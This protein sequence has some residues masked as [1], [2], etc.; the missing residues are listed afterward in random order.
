MHDSQVSLSPCV[1][2]LAPDILVQPSLHTTNSTHKKVKTSK[3][4]NHAHSSQEMVEQEVQD[5]ARRWTRHT[6]VN[7]RDSCV[8]IRIRSSAFGAHLFTHCGK[9][10]AVS[11]VLSA[12]RQYRKLDH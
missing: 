5:I 1:V 3:R 2:P 6:S 7:R 12:S 11:G 4:R 9:F 10:C 8:A